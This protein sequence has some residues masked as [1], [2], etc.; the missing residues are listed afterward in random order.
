MWLCHT[1]LGFHVCQCFRWLAFLAGFGWYYCSLFRDRFYLATRLALNLRSSCVH[2]SSVRLRGKP[3]TLCFNFHFPR[4]KLC[5]VSLHTFVC[6]PYIQLWSTPHQGRWHLGC[7]MLMNTQVGKHYTNLRCQSLAFCLGF[8]F[9]RTL[10]HPILFSLLLPV[11]YWNP[12]LSKGVCPLSVILPCGLIA[13]AIGQLLT[14]QALYHLRCWAWVTSLV[15][16]YFTGWLRPW[17]QVISG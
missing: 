7:W 13:R 5:L 9:S 16:D 4:N 8:A 12:S 15:F 17:T 1:L 10:A 11:F 2:L 6:H 3:A 14:K